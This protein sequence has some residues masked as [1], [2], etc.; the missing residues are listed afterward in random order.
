MKR[1]GYTGV[2]LDH[3]YTSASITAPYVKLTYPHVRKVLVVGMKS[4][5]DSMEAE[6]IEVIGAE[7]QILDADVD[8]NETTF[9][10]FE[11]DPDVGAVVSGLDVGFTHQKLCLA[12]LYL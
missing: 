5:R 9:D 10:N 1:M 6:G 8:F 2:K 4:L 7:Q 11:V 3:I 12:S